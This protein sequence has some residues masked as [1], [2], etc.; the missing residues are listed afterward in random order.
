MDRPGRRPHHRPQGLTA[1]IVRPARPFDYRCELR[2][3][4]RVCLTRIPEVRVPGLGHLWTTR[5]RGADLEAVSPVWHMSTWGRF[6]ASPS[7]RPAWS[8]AGR[9]TRPAYRTS[10]FA[11]ESR[12]GP[13]SAWEGHSSYETWQ[14]ARTS[15]S[16]GYSLSMSRATLSS[17]V[18]L[19]RVWVAGTFLDMNSSSS[20]STTALPEFQGFVCF[21]GHCQP[22]PP[23]GMACA[24]STG[25]MR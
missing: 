1:A 5:P 20:S 15:T 21:E 13:G 18:P 23:L 19:R 4:R 14:R 7:I 10:P 22:S 24:W 11:R 17:P 2:E 16:P 25:G 12:R 9:L 6:E 3:F 8:R